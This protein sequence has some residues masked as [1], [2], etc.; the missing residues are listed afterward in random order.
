M[1]DTFRDDYDHNYLY[2]AI[3]HVFSSSHDIEMTRNAV[4]VE[5]LNS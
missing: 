4:A 1:R 3:I 2:P 5:V